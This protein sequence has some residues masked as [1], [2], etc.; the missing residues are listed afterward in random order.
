M[1]PTSLANTLPDELG[2]LT[3]SWPS[4]EVPVGSDAFAA[5]VTVFHP[6]DGV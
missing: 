4:G 1:T 6:N 2:H 3:V 5:T